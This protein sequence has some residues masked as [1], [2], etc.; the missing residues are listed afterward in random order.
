VITVVAGRRI[1]HGANDAL[2]QYADQV[3]AHARSILEA[4]EAMRAVGRGE[5]PKSLPPNPT[6]EACYQ[7]WREDL[8]SANLIEDEVTRREA[9]VAAAIGL[10][11]CLASVVDKMK[12]PPR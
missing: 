2:L 8:Q 12:P 3:E 5:Q 4:A 11:M 9:Q 10:H 6:A 7:T 1:V